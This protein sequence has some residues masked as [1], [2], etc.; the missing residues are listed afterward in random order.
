[1]EKNQLIELIK[2]NRIGEAL[3]LV[4]K[5]VEGTDLQNEVILL[6]S[7]FSEYS[8]LNRSATEDFNT[9]EMQRN[10]IVNRLLSFLDD[11]PPETLKQIPTPPP[12]K[13]APAQPA[14]QPA[15]QSQPAYQAGSDGAPVW[16]KYGIYL[17]GGLIGL[18]ILINVLGGGDPEP[19]AGEETATMDQAQEHTEE[20]S[21]A[22]NSEEALNGFNTEWFRVVSPGRNDTVEFHEVDQVN[23]L[24]ITSET[25][26]KDFVL[27][28]R[29]EWSVYLRDNS[30]GV[31]IQLDMYQNSV[32]YSDDTGRK[33][34]LYDIIDYGL[35][36]E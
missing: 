34:K 22:E 1:M 11:L 26:Q 36:D 30:R 23:W 33:F 13:A 15:F 8:K 27:V 5:A 14:P 12:V 25:D 6:S 20:S 35:Y 3:N 19:A 2:Q 21:A 31:D 17:I 7:T 32:I 10:R 18:I 9:L 16:K 29:D 4:E 28:N 24:E